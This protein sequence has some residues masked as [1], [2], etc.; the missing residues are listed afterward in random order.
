M[1]YYLIELD[2]DDN[3]TLLGKKV[4]SETKE[5]DYSKPSV[6]YCNDQANNNT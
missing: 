5:H 3:F 6:K 4:L 2:V 1:P